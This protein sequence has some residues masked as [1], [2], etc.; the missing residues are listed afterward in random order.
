VTTNQQNRENQNMSTWGD[1]KVGG[2]MSLLPAGIRAFEVTTARAE[3]ND[4][5]LREA[6]IGLSSSAGAGEDKIALEPWD[7]SFDGTEM[8]ERIFKGAA[9]GLGFQPSSDQVTVEQAA[10]EFAAYV[11]RLVGSMVEVEV[12]HVNGKKLKDDGTPF[13]NHRV[14]YRQIV[15]QSAAVAGAVT[16]QVEPA[17]FAA[18][19]TDDP[20]A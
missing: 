19:A 16:T 5:G 10:N 2:G 6:V 9:Q 14:N 20:W 18:A 17:A 3:V 12:K 11:P 7:K 8:W 4:R 15:G 1:V 13:V